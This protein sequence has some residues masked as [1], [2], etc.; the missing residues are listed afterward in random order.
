VNTKEDT[1]FIHGEY[2]QGRAIWREIQNGAPVI[3]RNEGRKTS[4]PAVFIGLVKQVSSPSFLT[5]D[6]W[7]RLAL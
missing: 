4:F 3:L 6:S 5:A 1:S 7:K 2:K